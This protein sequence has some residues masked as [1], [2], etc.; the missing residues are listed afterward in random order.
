[1]G[2][3]RGEFFKPHLKIFVQSALDGIDEDTRGNV[4]CIDQYE[5][6]L[7]PTF[8]YGFLHGIGYID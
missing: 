7:N 5:S 3:L 1:V 2:I 4:H 6:F 8:R